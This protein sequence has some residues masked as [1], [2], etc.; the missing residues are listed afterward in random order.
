[1]HYF[2]IWISQRHDFLLYFSC[3]IWIMAIKMTGTIKKHFP[4][5][6]FVQV[7]FFLEMQLTEI[8]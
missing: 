7:I 6:D 8:L 4:K 5:P 3:M 2:E 1:M